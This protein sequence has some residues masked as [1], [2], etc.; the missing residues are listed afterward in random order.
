FHHVVE[1]RRHQ[2]LPVQAPA[3]ENLGHGERMR[4]VGFAGLARLAGMRGAGEAISLRQA[5]NVRRLQIT[6]AALVK[7]WN[8]GH[9][10]SVAPRTGN[11]ALTR[12]SLPGP[13]PGSG[14]PML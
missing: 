12:I 14:T 2:R 4:N 6:E 1:Q 3:R 13:P 9:W 10:G 5:R 8:G 11:R 7:Y